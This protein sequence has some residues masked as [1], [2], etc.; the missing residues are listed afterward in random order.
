[1]ESQVTKPVLKAVFR[2]MISGLDARVEDKTFYL[3]DEIA[4]ASYIGFL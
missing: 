1:M 2:D 3:A 4:V